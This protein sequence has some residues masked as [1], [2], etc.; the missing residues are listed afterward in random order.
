MRLICLTIISLTL[1]VPAGI[2]IPSMVWGALFGRL[3]GIAMQS[4]QQAFPD[5]PL[6][7]SCPPADKTCVTPGMYALLGAFGSLGGVTRL[8]LTLT[9]IMF[10]LTGTLNY[11][12]PCMIVLMVAKLVGDTFGKGGSTDAA[13][14]ANG[15]PFLD[16][17]E[18]EAI[19]NAGAKNSNGNSNPL[20]Q[21][22]MT[23]VHQLT[24]MNKTLLTIEE[25]E[26]LLEDNVG[27]F[28]AYPVVR[29]GVGREFVGMVGVAEMW[30]AVQAA[31]N[32][33]VLGESRR[34]ETFFRRDSLGSRE[35]LMHHVA[36]AMVDVAPYLN[37][38]PFTVHPRMQMEFVVDMFRKLGPRY[39]VV[40]R[41]GRLEGL[42]TKKDLLRTLHEFHGDAETGETAGGESVVASDE[43]DAISLLVREA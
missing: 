31:K 40:L 42:I 29:A 4:V 16:A 1:K 41:D 39:L 35:G 10:E 27:Q 37:R 19:L 14:S 15:Y 5:F 12:V 32:E 20:A 30:T 22:A 3:T 9:I 38:T 25:A 17:D 7:S 23:P 13:I 26:R 18:T 36:D 43:G 8:T 21:D 11:I 33:G 2:F 24:V 34:S 6:F 28:R